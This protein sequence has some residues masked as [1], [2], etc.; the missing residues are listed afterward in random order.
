ME[1]R[2]VVHFLILYCTQSCDE[3]QFPL[4]T[5]ALLRVTVFVSQFHCIP[6]VLLY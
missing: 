1:N 2:S 4:V 6:I 3:T 5:D